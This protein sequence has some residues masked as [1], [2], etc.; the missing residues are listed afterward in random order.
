MTVITIQTWFFVDIN[1]TTNR[2]WSLGLI[3]DINS[4]KW[5]VVVRFQSSRLLIHS[6]LIWNEAIIIKWPE[7]EGLR[8]RVSLVLDSEE[9]FGRGYVGW[10]VGWRWPMLKSEDDPPTRTQRNR[11]ASSAAQTSSAS[12]RRW[13]AL[14]A[15]KSLV[16]HRNKGRKTRRRRRRRIG[17]RKFKVFASL[18]GLYNTRRWKF[19][20]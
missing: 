2:K 10:L 9:A 12:R 15:Y 13:Y 16:V 17:R 7:E 5:A 20:Q 19:S 18:S 4:E 6:S 8:F 14:N 3:S 11:R 1:R